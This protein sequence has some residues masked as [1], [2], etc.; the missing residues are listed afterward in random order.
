ML[1]DRAGECEVMSRKLRSRRGDHGRNAF[2]SFSLHQRIYVKGIDQ[3]LAA[4][5]DG[6]GDMPEAVDRALIAAD[7]MQWRPEAAKAVLLIS[8]APPHRDAF[9]AT[10]DA[11]AHLREQGVRIVPIAASGVED[12]AQ[13]VMRA[14]AALTG[15]RYIFLTDDS[16]IGNGH[17]EPNIDCYVVTRLNQLIARVLAGIVGGHRVEPEQGEII[18]TVGSYDRGRCKTTQIQRTDAQVEHEG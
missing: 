3:L 8:D 17:A 9:G 18:R 16:G 14:M 15:G 7:D 5:A 6:G 4:H 2:S 1:V 11:V 12:S 10:L 13:Y